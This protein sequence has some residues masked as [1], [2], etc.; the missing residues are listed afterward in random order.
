MRDLYIESKIANQKKIFESANKSNLIVRDFK[1]IPFMGVDYTA[2]KS[3]PCTIYGSVNAVVAL[4]GNNNVKTW[5]SNNLN[6]DYLLKYIKEDFLNKDGEIVNVLKKYNFNEEYVFIK[7]N[8]W[9]KDFK[10][11][12]VNLNGFENIGLI[13]Q[14]TI[15]DGYF[16][17]PLK[18]IHSETRSWIMGGK[19]IDAVVYD[20]DGYLINNRIEPSAEVIKF[21]K[22]IKN[23]IN[24]LQKY[25]LDVVETV[26]GV[27]VLELGCVNCSGFY[28][29]DIEKILVELCK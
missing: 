7:P 5:Q 3:K 13:Y 27:K 14:D 21:I 28:N 24:P 6:I 8:S 10:G 18:K 25:V 16:I 17:A 29:A 26:E 11:E 19:I 23:K 9:K 20:I 1:Y 15:V 22:K 12:V 4:E 2:F